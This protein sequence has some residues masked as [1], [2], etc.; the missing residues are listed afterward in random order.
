MLAVNNNSP[1]GMAGPAHATK[2]E[3]HAMAHGLPRAAQRGPR[4]VQSCFPP[5]RSNAAE[6]CLRTRVECRAASSLLI[7]A[8]VHAAEA[9]VGKHAEARFKCQ[10][11]PM[12]TA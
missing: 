2:Y 6:A 11:V 12:T 7:P 3:M 5:S 4:Q 10:R 8:S 9:R 1:P